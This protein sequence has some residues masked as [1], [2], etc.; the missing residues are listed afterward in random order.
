MS[1]YEE[2]DTGEPVDPLS[3]NRHNCDSDQCRRKLQK[4][5]KQFHAGTTYP[6]EVAS[7]LMPYIAK[8]ATL[9]QAWDARERRERR[10]PKAPGPDGKRYGD[11]VGEHRWGGCRILRGK[12]L[13]GEYRSRPERV[14]QVPKAGGNGTRPIVLTSIFDRV[15]HHAIADT[16]APFVDPKLDPHSC[17]YRSKRDRRQALALAEL[18]TLRHERS[19][20]VTADIRDAFEN[21]RIERLL[22]VVGKWFPDDRLIELI[23]RSL[24]RPVGSESNGQGLRQGSCLSP[25]LMNMY[26]DHFID[27]PW[28]KKHPDVPMLRYADD[29][30]ILANSEVIANECFDDLKTLIAPNGL[31]LKNPNA[32]GSIWNLDADPCP[33]VPWLGFRIWK[34]RGGLGVKVPPQS[35][36]KFAEK[37][38]KIHEFD[39]PSLRVYHSVEGWFTQ[40]GPCFTSMKR[41]IVYRRIADLCR[42]AGFDE[43]PDRKE[44]TDRWGKAYEEWSTLKENVSRG[45]STPHRAV[46]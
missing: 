16:L 38:A 7:V 36:D 18:Y 17:G 9:H 21:I 26:F 30:L 40:Q 11:F 20:W 39:N 14:V 33:R 19:F 2:F 44:A 37:L 35:Y 10:K 1:D 15:V 42:E 5:A 6:S 3:L 24:Q 45:F 41:D 8:A 31:A 29:L 34:H 4:L 28:R 43:I 22:D 32:E 13:S 25:L 46:T 27:K 23:R 12:I